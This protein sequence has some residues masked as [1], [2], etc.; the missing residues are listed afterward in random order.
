MP[1][2]PLSALRHAS[3][4]VQTSLTVD[5]LRAALA[6]QV[7]GALWV[8]LD[9]SDPDQ[10]AILSS[11]FHFHPLAIEDAR[12]PNSRVKA[13][14][15]PDFLLVVARVVGF[16]ETTPDPYDLETANLTLFL[17]ERAIVTTH[18][19][20]LPAVQEMVERI[21]SN[22]DLLARGPARLA[23]HVLDTA[24][25]AYF[26]VLDRLDEFV[27]DM[28]QRVFGQFDDALLQ[29]IFKVKRLVITLRRYLAPQRE[30]LSQLTMRPS[31]F[32][33]TDAQLYFRDVYDHML[34]ITDALDSYRDLLSSTLDSYLT[35][36]SNRLGTVSKGLAV[37]GALSLPFVVIAGVYGMNFDRIPLAHHPWGFEIMLG[38]QLGLSA[39]L[40]I[41]F[42]LRGVL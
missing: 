32:L 22:P 24:V 23:H 14:E 7:D 39:V 3:G 4:A 9:V 35:Q 38:V 42:R 15:Y 10:A 26:P 41:A 13:E 19:E 36:V 11:V 28:E 6:E 33:P 25:D 21:R 12:N 8:D 37:V 5:E 30:V 1:S 40:L 17:T 34:R 2:P 18:M 16:C 29:E 31:R 27:D 20:K